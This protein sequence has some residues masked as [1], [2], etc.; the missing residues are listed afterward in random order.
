M[1][2]LFSAS[3]KNAGWIWHLCPHAPFSSRKLWKGHL[4][5]VHG[6]KSAKAQEVSS[7]VS[8]DN[9]TSI[10]TDKHSMLKSMP[11]LED[12]SD[13][14]TEGSLMNDKGCATVASISCDSPTVS[15]SAKPLEDETSDDE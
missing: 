3:S 15:D 10:G 5:L 8:V 14:E 7:V 1:C 11:V 4:F 9:V 12:I 6:I 13:A 2:N